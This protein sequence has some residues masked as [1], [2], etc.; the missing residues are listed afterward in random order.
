[1][2]RYVFKLPD[3]GEGTV[4]AEIVG[5]RVKPGDVVAED[6]VVVEV[7][8]EKAAVEVP[9]PVS[10]SVVSTTGAPGDMVPVGAELI[11][12]ET[13]GA[14]ATAPATVAAAGP[15][16]APARAGAGGANG[17][18][19]PMA[20]PA[21]ARS[22]RVATSPAIRRRAHEAGVDL[23]QVAGT[24]P[25]GRI[26]PKD[27]E[28]YVAR[29]VQPTPLRSA[30]KAVPAARPAAPAAAT[31]E[32]KV[33]GL[34]RLIAQRMSE[35]KRTIPH[36]A[37]VE[38][39]DITELESLRRHLNGRLPAGSA[40]LTYLPFL[41]LGLIRVLREFPQ[42]NAHYDAER[43]VILRY[44]AVHLG[45]ATQTPEGLKVPVV[46]D[47]QALSLWEL[48]AAMR[49]VSE[50]ARTNKAKREEL[51]GSTITITSLGKLGGIASTPII[52]APE[53]AIIGVNRAIE[54]PLVIEGAI[55][56]RLTMN[57]SSSFDHRF[58][59]GY[60]AASM[61]QALK[62]CLEHPATIF[63]PP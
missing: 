28:A 21:S 1:M 57:L 25:N 54:R 41:A 47:A 35:A 52:N 20:A 51:T 16:A 62:E 37:Y 8:T 48:A 27:L 56:I 55:A 30:P 15:P 13:G 14:E 9:S 12:L 46:H 33:I 29:R 38:E 32:I 22:A 61:I 24:G 6:D 34:R 59:D 3:L 40:P 4:E 5:W 17:G 63:I 18:T 31:E 45:I 10:G 26:V 2:S 50:A 11:V 39:L 58:V 60:D 43:G 23:R 19:A 53:V 7:M 36:F 49:R 44:S 42:C